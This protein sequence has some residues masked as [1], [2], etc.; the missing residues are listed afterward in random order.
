MDFWDIYDKHYEQF[1][2]F[3]FVPV[4]NDL[5]DH[6]GAK[7]VGEPGLVPTAPMPSMMALR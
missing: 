3:I 7:G 1:R 6:F 5:E 4:K 2:K